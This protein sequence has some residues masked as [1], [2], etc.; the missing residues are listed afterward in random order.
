M[1]EAQILIIGAG[2]TGLVL[3]VW[4]AHL[5]IKPRIV[6]KAD[7]PGKTSRAV[8]VQ[9]RT[10]ELYSPLGLARSV[11]EN[12]LQARAMNIWAKGKHK[13][14]LQL[15]EI[16]EDLS[17]FPYL[18]IYPQDEHE[19]L[20]IERLHEMGVRVE[21]PVECVGLMARGEKVSA[22][23]RHS[24]GSIETCEADYVAGCD[25]AHSCIRN[26][27]GIGFSGGTYEHLFYVADVEASGPTMNGE[28][29]F[30]LENNGDFLACLALDPHE[31]VRLIGTMRDPA[32]GKSGDLGWE[33]VSKLVIDRLRLDVKRVN[34]FS[35]YRVHHRVASSFRVGRT[36]I[37]GDA[38]HIHSPVGGQGMNT[39]I[40]DASNLAWKLVSV[41]RGDAD[42]L[43]LDTFE[44]E[45]LPFAN[46]LVKTT[47]RAFT[48]LSSSNP[49][50]VA[51][52]VNIVPQLVSKLFHFKR[53]RRLLFN[54]VS[55]IKVNYRNS[56]LSVG[57]AGG[58]SGGDRL[59]WIKQPDNEDNFS[60]LTG[61]DWQVHV[62]GSASAALVS[63]C[64]AHALP[65]RIFPW[66]HR[67]GRVVA[68]DAAYL[69]RP[70]GYIALAA[71]S[72]GEADKLE[73]YLRRQFLRKFNNSAATRPSRLG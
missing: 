54:T 4:L 1:P 34:W 14:R 35:T 5:G 69:I 62:Y 46:R 43:L 21:R 63:A 52:R 11:V 40:G 12:G 24:D 23:L 45:R 51:V 57:I 48:M 58:V 15:G 71:N 37:L 6:D 33:D 25:G 10:L 9:A 13:G 70:D 60:V 47:D 16:G 27:L 49:L 20:L 32:Q 36:F 59:P 50:A 66:D 17:P 55:Q 19:K 22:Q 64:R 73:G 61:L 18:L 29:H 65:L 38:A 42:P 41:I 67:T 26:A 28:A 53:V 7:A 30:A 2:P 44:E 31:H 39:G 3:A 72:P 68:R 56:K 8:G